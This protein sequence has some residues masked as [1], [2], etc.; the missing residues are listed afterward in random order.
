MSP[1]RNS[2]MKAPPLSLGFL[3][4][5]TVSTAIFQPH[6]LPA[7]D[8]VPLKVQDGVYHVPVRINNV[9]TLDFIIDSG[10]SDVVIPADVALTLVRAGTIDGTD[11]LP[12]A[13]YQLADGSIVSSPRFVIREL[14]IGSQKLMNVVASISNISGSLL[15]GQTALRRLADWRFDYQKNKLVLGANPILDLSQVSNQGVD[16][17]VRYFLTTTD[18]R[19]ISSLIQIYDDNVN[20]FGKGY[21]TKSF[22]IDDKT[23]YFRRWPISKTAVVGAIQIYQLSSSLFEA[24]FNTNFYA[25]N[26]KKSSMGIANNIIQI[27]KDQGRYRICSEKQVVVNRRR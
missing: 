17:F 21:V 27:R 2:V 6:N 1:P 24:H 9:I 16:N 18:A 8:E 4:T 20:Y 19:D 3:F 7:Q 13:E 22:I 26:A 11:F 15:L 23:S 14:M 12:G 25:V 10:A 5:I